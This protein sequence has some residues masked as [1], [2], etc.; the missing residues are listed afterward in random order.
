MVY[1]CFKNPALTQWFLKL[2]NNFICPEFVMQS[3]KHFT[4]SMI[5]HLSNIKTYTYKEKAELKLKH[6]I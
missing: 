2:N 6:K 1:V 5:A 3:F 4:D